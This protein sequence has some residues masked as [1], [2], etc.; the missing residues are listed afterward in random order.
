MADVGGRESEKRQQFI[1]SP[2]LESLP[3]VRQRS[4]DVPGAKLYEGEEEKRS[5]P[6]L[7]NYKNEK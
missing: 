3:V 7:T 5:T 1:Q 6:S 2:Y 4:L